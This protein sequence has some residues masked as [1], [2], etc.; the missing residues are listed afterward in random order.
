M[1]E[2]STK[3]RGPVGFL[4]GAVILALSLPAA[5]STIIVTVDGDEDRGEVLTSNVNTL[6]I[7]RDETGYMTVPV[8]DIERVRLEIEGA[9]P[10]EGRFLDWRDGRWT[11]RV[12]DRLLSV[13]G[14]RITSD[15]SLT[16][17][18][19]S[20]AEQ[21]PVETEP[22]IPPA[23]G[24]NLPDPSPPAAAPARPSE[25]ARQQQPA[26]PAAEP[27]DNP[28]RGSNVTM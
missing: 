25:P 1:A 28:G 13:E 3:G 23:G 7:K 21:T 12:G 26:L 8:G 16:T 20:V 15:T 11:I 4:I 6:I 9:S 22:V 5:A 19:P 27:A 14:G 10:V 17:V 24:P 18:R 2:C